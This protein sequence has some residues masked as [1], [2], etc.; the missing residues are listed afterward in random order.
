MSKKAFGVV[1]IL[2]ICVICTIAIVI[3]FTST[4]G[5]DREYSITEPY[6][7]DSIINTARWR[8]MPMR[9]ARG[10]ELAIPENIYK[11]MT[12]KALLQSIVSYPFLIDLF[13]FNSYREGFLTL[14][15]E[16]EE[17]YHEIN[18]LVSRDDFGAVL[19]N[20]YTDMP[21]IHP[22]L[23]YNI[24]LEFMEILVAQPEMTGGLPDRDLYAIA[25]I[26]KQ[27]HDEKA[28]ANQIYSN[29][30]T[31]YIAANE[32]NGTALQSVLSSP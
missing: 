4:S 30:N 20:E 1:A 6:D 24:Y 11:N 15:Q 17:L 7:Y 21:V 19:I 8:G 10:A 31:L 3:H 2:V 29:P 22:E 18:E 28:A 9:S 14:Y 27:K 16:R 13:A 26:A 5:S 23:E 12:T 25:E 32:N